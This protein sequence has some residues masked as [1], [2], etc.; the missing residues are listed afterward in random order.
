[1]LAARGW[2][3]AMRPRNIA[4]VTLASGGVIAAIAWTGWLRPRL[5]DVDLGLL[6]YGAAFAV[7]LALGHL[8]WSHLRSPRV[9][10]SMAIGATMLAVGC[11]VAT[12]H[13][14]YRRPFALLDVWGRTPVAGFAIGVT[15]DV[16][17]VRNSF[18]LGELRVASR[19]G[20]SHP[21]I[22]LVTVDTFRADRSSVYGGAARTRSLERAA[23]EGSVFR[24]AFAPGN[25]TRRSIPAIATGLSPG[26]VRGRVAGWALRLDPRHVTVAE[27]FAASGYDTAGFFC[28]RSHFA[29]EHQLG[30]DRG[31]DHLVIERDVSDLVAAAVDCQGE[32]ERRR[33]GRPSLVWLHVIEPHTW[34]RRA[35]LPAGK[36]GFKPR[37]DALLE[38]VDAALEPLVAFATDASRRDRTVLVV[39]S[40]HGEGLGDHGTV[41]HAATLYNSE[42]RV[43]LII[44]GGD[45]KKQRIT[46]PVGLTD[47]APTLL[48]LAGFV[49][50][51]MPVMDG[52]SLAPYL[53]GER[54][55]AVED[56][57]AYSLMIA[58]RSV[59]RT[60]WALVSGRHKLIVEPDAPPQLYDIV[61][62]PDESANLLAAEPEVLARLRAR[63]DERRRT[64]RVSPF[65]R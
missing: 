34:R 49:P 36:P 53:R 32:R 23:R 55:A 47:L 1:M 33:E 5:G 8:A 62:D 65:G 39:T 3:A 4:L 17:L 2:S 6:P 15:Y 61:S 10:R 26:R 35:P 12:V 9:R 30:T 48:D 57:E 14:R 21:T 44:S 29:R 11:S 41:H 28:C 25:V 43:P 18:A 59:R 24:W 13:A 7:V 22:I 46:M 40:D 51:S 52:R 19:P 38:E 16:Q 31:I 37:Y 27:R 58:D 64:D 54:V 60:M 45:V 42:I 20:A 50:P 56:G 63:L